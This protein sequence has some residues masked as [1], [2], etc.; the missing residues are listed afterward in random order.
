VFA[1]TLNSCGFPF[2]VSLRKAQKLINQVCQ[3]WRDRAWTD[4]NSYEREYVIRYVTAVSLSLAGDY[5]GAVAE[6]I[7]SMGRFKKL[8]DSWGEVDNQI[9]AGLVFLSQ[10]RWDDAL[11]YLRPAYEQSEKIDYPVGCAMAA[12]GLKALGERVHEN[13]LIQEKH[14]TFYANHLEHLFD[15]CKTPFVPCYTLLFP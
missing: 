8:K 4:D 15:I 3:K 7:Q 5:D 2:T 11:T 12:Y 9:N 6:M 14:L 10:E 13:Y 1:L